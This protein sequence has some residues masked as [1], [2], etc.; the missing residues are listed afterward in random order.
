MS[1]IENGTLPCSAYLELSNHNSSL[2]KVIIG[3]F[4]KET[5]KYHDKSDKHMKC[6]RK[7]RAELNP[8]ATELAKSMKSLDKKHS[9]MYDIL[10]KT[11]YYIAKNKP[12]SK[13]RPLTEL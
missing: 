7:Q 12:F 4:S 6:I 10:F 8:N 2:T 5:L 11:A 1:I 3:K 13:F 9:F